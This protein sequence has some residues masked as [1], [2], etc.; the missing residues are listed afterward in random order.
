[1]LCLLA[2]LTFCVCVCYGNVCMSVGIY[3]NEYETHYIHLSSN[4]IVFGNMSSSS[5]LP[6]SSYS[7][8]NAFHDIHN[9]ITSHVQTGWSVCIKGECYVN[10]TL[11]GIHT[12]YILEQMVLIITWNLNSTYLVVSINNTYLDNVQSSYQ[13]PLNVQLWKGWP[14]G[15]FFQPYR[16]SAF[17]E[18]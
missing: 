10:C 13:F 6:F 9:I 17:H 11:A 14:V 5:P 3:V 18:Q 15:I 16:Q 8:K 2:M 7:Q 4:D 1:M 12:Y